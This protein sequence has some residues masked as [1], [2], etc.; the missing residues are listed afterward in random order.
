MNDMVYAA[1]VL[2]GQRAQTIAW[3]CEAR[4]RQLE[5]REPD[6]RQPRRLAA[7]VFGPIVRL[8]SRRTRRV[9]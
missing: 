1:S 6:A 5:R 4:R 7:E 3:E 9:A 2:A 8:P